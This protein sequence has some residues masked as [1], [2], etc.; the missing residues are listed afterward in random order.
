MLEVMPEIGQHAL[1]RMCQEVYQTGRTH[2][3]Q[4]SHIPF[5]RPDDAVV[6]DRYFNFIQQP[7]YSE[8]GRIDGVVVFAFEVT[9]Q[10]QARQQVQRL[11]EQLAASNAALQA[12]N[13]ELSYTN[14][15][16]THTNTDLDT[17]VYTA[18]HDLKSPIANIEGL[19]LALRAQLPEEVLTEKDTSHLLDLMHGSVARFQHTLSYLT[20]VSKLQLINSELPEAVDL[21]AL[22]ESVRLDLVPALKTAGGRF[23]MDITGCSTIRFSPKNLR[24]IL[25]NL[26]SNALKYRDPGRPLYVQLR[27]QCAAEQVVLEVQDNGLGLNEEQQAKLFVLFQRLHTH[28][29]GTG[30]GLYMVKRLVENAGGTVQVQSQPGMGSTFRVLLPT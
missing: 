2:E 28:V 9:E 22:A 18:S 20:D 21:A 12:S 26:L 19:L 25:Y 10:V 27:C 7:R 16:L 23:T 8:Q 30:V 5:A 1:G 11:N 13:Q 17:F 29:E 6:E 24:S 14:Q 3:A 15:R 4:E